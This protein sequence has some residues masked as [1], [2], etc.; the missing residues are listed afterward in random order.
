[1]LYFNDWPDGVQFAMFHSKYILLQVLNEGGHKAIDEIQ[2]NIK[3]SDLNP[4]DLQN[5]FTENILTDR[6]FVVDVNSP[7][8]RDSHHELKQ[9]QW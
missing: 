5:L 2:D 6:K 8:R 1:M 7:H 3:K 4:E 9:N